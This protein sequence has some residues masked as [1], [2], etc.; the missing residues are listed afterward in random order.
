MGEKEPEP[1]M[2][3]DEDVARLSTAETLR[4]IAD[5]VESK[6]IVITHLDRQIHYRT[7]LDVIGR[8]L[9]KTATG[10]SFQIELRY[11]R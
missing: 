11:V 2:L 5:Q 1:I 10:E 7:V 9:E 3:S 8:V 6:Q 4:R